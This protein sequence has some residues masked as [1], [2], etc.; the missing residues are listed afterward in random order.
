MQEAAKTYVFAGGGTAGHISPA[1]ATA[2]ALLR[3]EPDAEVVMLGTERG[4]ETR[5][6]PEHGYELE[7][8]PPVPLPRRPSPDLLRLPGRVRAAVAQ[9]A[10]I[11]RRRGADAVVGF[12]GYVS[13]P[14]YLA[15][16]RVGVPLVIHEANAKPGLAN[17]VGARYATTVAVAEAAAGR[18]PNGVVVGIPIR[19]SITSLDRPAKRDEAREF[20][21]LDHERPTLLVTGGSQGAR[22]INSAIEQAADAI[23]AAGGQILHAVGP[24]NAESAIP[25]DGYLPVPYIDHMDLAYAAADMIVCRS[26]AITCAE[27][28]AVGLP[29]VYVPLPHGNGEQRFNALPVVDGG[30]GLLVSD[31]DLTPEWITTNVVPLLTNK[32]RLADMG[33]AAATLGHRNADDQLVALIRR[34]ADESPEKGYGGT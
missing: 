12:G 2:D 23:T 13:L 1:L 33:R 19:S 5:L 29:A 31:S 28:S 4:L 6:V 34:A 3:A 24:A 30:G 27:V 21:K 10:G 16:R 8:I 32:D 9:T 22:R 25:R 7:L 20:Y 11:L 26:G 18:L 15:A 17:R 14:A